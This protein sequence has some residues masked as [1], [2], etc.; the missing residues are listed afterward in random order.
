MKLKKYK[1]TAAGEVYLKN[2]KDKESN[3]KGILHTQDKNKN[4]LAV[5]IQQ[6]TDDTAELIMDTPYVEETKAA[7]S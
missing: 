1:L 2:A 4:P 3:V 7:S 5:D 6:L